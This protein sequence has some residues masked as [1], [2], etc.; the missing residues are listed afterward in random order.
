LPA[1]SSLRLNDLV[2]FARLQRLASNLQ[3]D[4]LLWLAGKG[5]AEHSAPVGAPAESI[6]FVALDRQQQTLGAGSPTPGPAQQQGPPN[7]RFQRVFAVFGG[8]S[9]RRGQGSGAKVKGYLLLPASAVPV[10][11][12]ATQ[13]HYKWLANPW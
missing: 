8:E 5:A 13:K 3:P 7:S 1:K 4:A 9:T 12:M 10:S 6:N 11:C 2:T